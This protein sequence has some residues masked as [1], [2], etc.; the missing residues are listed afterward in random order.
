MPIMG[1]GEGREP[2]I[3]NLCSDKAQLVVGDEWGFDS[4]P[5]ISYTARAAESRA[6]HPWR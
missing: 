1:R 5:G 6:T 4:L 3:V 2:T